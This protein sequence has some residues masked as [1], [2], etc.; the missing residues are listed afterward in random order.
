MDNPD[1]CSRCHCRIN[2]MRQLSVAL[3]AL[4]TIDHPEARLALE[5]I[6]ILANI[7]ECS[8]VRPETD[9]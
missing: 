5:S 6:A 3:G 9:D 4:K 7:K 2:E 8:H 1:S